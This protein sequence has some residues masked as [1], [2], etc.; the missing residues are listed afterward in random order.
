MN[1]TKTVVTDEPIKILI[2]D[3]E[4]SLQQLYAKALRREGYSMETAGTG[5]EALKK[6][7]EFSPDI[8]LLDIGLPD[9]SGFDI[10][11]HIRSSISFAQV[12]VI[13]VT[14]F[15]TS[16]EERTRGLKSGADDYLHKPVGMDVLLV[17]VKSLVRIRQTEN[18]LRLVN[19][20]LEKRVAQRTGELRESNRILLSEIREHKKAQAELKKAHDTL[21]QRIAE[22]TSQL[23]TVNDDLKIEIRERKK[24]QEESLGRETHLKT[25]QKIATLGSFFSDLKGNV[26]FSE[27][28]YQLFGYDPGEIHLSYQFVENHIYSKDLDRYKRDL[29]KFISKNTPIDQEYRIVCKKGSVREIR[30][31]GTVVFDGDGSPRERQGV[32]QDITE[33][34]AMERQA[35]QNEKLA[36]LGFLVSGVAHEINN[37]NNFISFNIPILRDYLAAILPVVDVHAQQNPGLE[38]CHMGYQA[39]RTDLLRLIGNIENGSHRIN[40]IVANL[41]QFAHMKNEVEYESVDI[42]KLING[43]VEISRGKINRLVKEFVVTLPEV[44]PPIHADSEI[45]EIAVINLIINAAQACDKEDSFVHL[46]VSYEGLQKNELT[47]E[48]RDNGCGMD[49]ETIS[50]AFDP[51]FSTKSSMEGTGIG[52]SLT[53][54]LVT[55]LGGRIELDSE[56]DQGSTF[57]L[58]IPNRMDTTP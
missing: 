34:K 49:S 7:N 1:K 57:R 14:G 56:P 11:A 53:H 36:S 38:V 16:V 47:I 58:I 50:R 5:K 17:R 4:V 25:A 13:V 35:I 43:C 40:K 18:K 23:Q 21:G 41:R 27:G 30:F 8:V 52:L 55:S 12:F 32:F 15:G 44:L 28:F 37:P 3:D 9:I 20:T 51:F 26:N 31:I 46:S 22:R 24:A 39:F 10:L 6:L 54:N 48:I 2:V 29:Q 19:K 45:L 33:K 42:C